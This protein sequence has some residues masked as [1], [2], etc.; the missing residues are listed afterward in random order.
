MF[1]TI[2]YRPIK[3]NWQSIIERKFHCSKIL[4]E[5][6]TLGSNMSEHQLADIDLSVL[7][8][9]DQ[10]NSK[11]QTAI[12]L[13]QLDQ[14]VVDEAFEKLKCEAAV[15][16]LLSRKRIGIVKLAAVKSEIEITRFE[17][18][19]EVSVEEELLGNFLIHCEKQVNLKE[20][21]GTL[22][23]EV[24]KI[25]NNHKKYLAS[26]KI[27]EVLATPLAIDSQPFGILF[28]YSKKSTHSDLS[29]ENTSLAITQFTKNDEN[30]FKLIARQAEN[31]YR[32]LKRYN[33]IKKINEVGV[34]I[35]S[36]RNTNE[37]LKVVTEAVLQVFEADIV[38][39]H[40]YSQRL[41]DFI[42]LPFTAGTTFEPQFVNRKPQKGEV[43][44]QVIESKK[45]YYASEATSDSFMSRSNV[46]TTVGSKAHFVFRE[47]IM[48]SAAILLRS[49]E[50]IVG[51]MFINFRRNKDFL[52]EEKN[53]MEVF[54]AHAAIAIKNAID[55]EQLTNKLTF[56]LS[57]LNSIRELTT[58]SS[59]D[60][61]VGV[62]IY[63]I[64]LDAILALL[65][66]K[67]GLYAEAKPENGRFIVKTTSDAYKKFERAS[68]SINEGI[69]GEALK[70]REIQIVYDSARDHSFFPL[71]EV[72]GRIQNLAREEVKSSISI[73]WILDDEVQGVFHIDSTSL[74]S[75]SEYDKL[76][77]DAFID[78]AAKS[79]QAAKLAIEKD[80]AIRKLLALRNLDH[81]IGSTW[82][83]DTVL[84]FIVDTV[85][86]LAK[87]EKVVVKLDL[88]ENIEGKPYLV[89][90]ATSG[91]DVEKK[92]V[93]LDSTETI[94][95]LSV[96]EN[97]VINVTAT[98]EFWKQNYSA[99]IPGML[100]ELAVPLR[101]RNKSIGVVYVESPNPKA[102]DKEDEVFLETLAGQAVIVI[103]M[104][105]VIHDHYCPVKIVKLVCKLLRT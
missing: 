63:K 27:R 77:L 66:A 40:L 35:S 3:T 65:D 80:F 18:E 90:Y 10:L 13:Q 30:L 79:I 69:T 29:K 104:T 96:V 14:V 38:T 72:E 36:S 55:K 68:W 59:A 46:P 86:E 82:N 11:L 105:R 83:L 42:G 84:E 61:K 103:Q 99:L 16:C 39:L 23:N 102:F 5:D 67:L 93:P 64:V 37:I 2:H 31:T 52:L 98:D 4:I 87:Q 53:L 32:S 85:V 57:K 62:S 58:S 89:P 9:V 15:L 71:S 7:E 100:S 12:S 56:S 101:V 48:S 49:N 50:D 70:T 28:V 25:F 1:P 21:R 54:A 22:P 81:L 6:T 33:D 44:F 95:C 34:V 94:A 88:I 73:P 75:F 20:L 26:N 78:Q 41:S 8:L 19:P 47:K 92:P 60:K 76:I 43:A 24:Q 74:E 97:R 17:N 45:N 51:V 91:V